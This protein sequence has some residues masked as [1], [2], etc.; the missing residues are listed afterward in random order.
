[1]SARLVP[2]LTS[3]RKEAALL[4]QVPRVADQIRGSMVF[5]G[6]GTTSAGRPTLAYASGMAQYAAINRN[7]HLDVGARSSIRRLISNQS[8]ISSSP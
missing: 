2:R 6:G 3:L 1:M 4:G 5:T 8:E 7:P